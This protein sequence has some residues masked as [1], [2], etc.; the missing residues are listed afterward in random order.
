MSKETIVAITDAGGRGAAEA[1]AYAR[2]RHVDK[3]IGIPGKKVWE[4]NTFGKPVLTFPNIKLTDREA[5]VQIGREYGVT[6]FDICQDNAVAAGAVDA[7]RGAGFRVVGPTARAGMIESDKIDARLLGTKARIFQPRFTYFTSEGRALDQLSQ[8]LAFLNNRRPEEEGC[9]VKAAGL[10]EGKGAIGA[11]N[12]VEV[13][14]AIKR[15][16]EFGEAGKRFLLEE[17]LRN[18]DG[19]PGEELS[20]FVLC[21]GEEFTYLGS[22]Q[23]NK[24]VGNRDEGP[25]TGGMGGHN[26]PMVLDK[27]LRERVESEVIAPVLGELAGEGRPYTGVLYFSGMALRRGKETIPYAVEFNAR[28]GDPEAQVILPGITN[29]W[30]EVGMTLAEGGSL[31][32]LQ[33]KSDGQKRVCVTVASLGYPDDYKAVKGKE[34]FGIEEAMGMVGVRVYGAGIRCEDKRHF[35]NGGRL[36]YVVGEGKDLLTA[37][38][39][40]YAGVSCILVDGNNQIYRDDIAI[41]DLARYYQ[42]RRAQ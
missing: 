34:I 8:I 17:W 38:R 31:K 32:D 23:D 24:A 42:S 20:Y 3:I 9:W 27:L 14:K 2:S 40:A 37:R 11:R 4:L 19:T 5:M 13:V 16:K 41:K 6:L 35:A 25:N 33:I 18:D 30:F 15:M 29:D 7:L 22:A 39:N 28:W 21:N 1:E 36:L 12:K 10:A 26:E